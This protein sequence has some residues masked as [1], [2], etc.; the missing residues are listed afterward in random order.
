MTLTQQHL[1]LQLISILI[2]I[3]WAALYIYEL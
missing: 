3:D 1:D 2:S